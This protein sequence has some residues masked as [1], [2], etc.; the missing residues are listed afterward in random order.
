M[1]S[2][3]IAASQHDSIGDAIEFVA[4]LVFLAALLGC[5]HRR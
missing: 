2:F 3:L 4:F 5:F 1:I